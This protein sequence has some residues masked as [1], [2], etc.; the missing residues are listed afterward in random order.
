MSEGY[1]L[2]TPEHKYPKCFATD[3]EIAMAKR[4]R[5]FVESDVMPNRQNLEG[6]WHRDEE[7]AHKTLYEL[8]YKAHELGLTI[9]NLP[10]QYGGLGL[11]PVVRNMI[12][13]E[14]SRGDVGLATLIGKVHWVVSFMYNRVLVR[15]DLLEEFA[16]KLTQKVPYIACVNI[17]EP[18]GGA[19]IEDPAQELR[20]LNTVIAKKDG[21]YW[22]LNGHKIWPGPA[23]DPSY[24]EK[25]HKKWPN[26]FAGHLGY[27]V[28]VTEDPSRGE[29]AAGIV[30]HPPDLPGVKF[31]EPYKK[32][33]FCWTDENCDIWYENA[34]VPLKYRID[35]KPGDGAKIIHG[36][37]IG[38]GRLAGAARLTGIATAVL[39]IALDWTK[40][41]YIVGKPVRER[42]YFAS[43][44]AEMYRMVDL[45][46]Q[47]YL[48]VTWQVMHPEIY[49]EPWD[50]HMIAKFS[51]ARSFAGDTAMF[52]CNK[53]MELMGS[54]GYTFEMN[55]EK[56]YRDFKIVQMWLGG[57]QRDRLDIAQGLYGPFKWGGWEEWLKTRFAKVKDPIEKEVNKTLSKAVGNE[58]EAER[59]RKELSKDVEYDIDDVKRG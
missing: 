52:C 11:S 36:Y 29:E 45:S 47:Y 12:N 4:I 21:D 22:V 49:G 58:R 16:P 31:G 9:S 59:I 10:R 15:H 37:V 33:G 3:E 55:V 25:W 32:C 51:A 57:A 35:T 27:W 39:E 54:Y 2:L 26:I 5:Q 8:Y 53:A 41:R 50:P 42:S 24:W 38:L 56:Y 46:R 30:Y 48:S 1:L 19:N 40:N 28:V 18:E 43:I 44:L 13:E 23:G 34:K 14:I 20:T 17:S 7:L 6:G